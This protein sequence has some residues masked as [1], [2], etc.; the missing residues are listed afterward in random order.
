MHERRDSERGQILVIVAGGLIALFTIVALVLEGGTLLLNRRDAQN[1]SD[2]AS[3]A[4]TRI[5]A[6]HHTAG[7]RTQQQVTQA[8]QTSLD[9]NQCPA[10]STTC[11][12]TARFVGAGLADIGA[13][14]NT[15]TAVPS[16]ALGV[17]V[18]VTRQVGALVGRVVG[19]TEWPVAAD[20]TAIAARPSQFPSG[21]MLPIALCGW[22]NPAGNDCVQASSSPSN[23]IDFQTGQVYDLTDGKDAPGGFGWL[24]WDGSNSAG[25]LAQS[26]CTPRNPSFSLDSPYDAIGAYGG[27]IGTNPSTGETWFPADP[28]KSNKS[29]M[30]TCLDGWI[31][32]GATVLIPVY[33][34]VTGNGNNAAYHITGVAAFVLTSREQPAVDNIQG[35]FVEYYPY[36][37]VPGG[38]GTQPPGPGDQTYFLGLVR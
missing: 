26:V 34:V 24:S 18:L 32:S 17:Q 11:T 2:L 7:G 25:A 36:T 15:G 20:A 6:L 33:D 29:D 35:Y 38:I 23:F 1:A 19:F 10:G 16:N 5:V 13:V 22:S 8:I 14:A 31:S 4:G 3:V 30:R 37:D 9:A 27:F 28:G 21:V 12:W